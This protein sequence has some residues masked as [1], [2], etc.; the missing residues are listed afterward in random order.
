MGMKNNGK[1]QLIFLWAARVL[2][3]FAMMIALTGCWSSI[4][5][6]HRAFVRVMMLDRTDK[7]IEVTLGFPLP[8]QIPSG[9]TSGSSGGSNSQVYTYTSKTAPSIGEAYRNL[10][11][12]LS[13]KIT[14]G[15]LRNIII[16]K[17]FAESK[18]DMLALSDFLVREPLIHINAS[19]FMTQS[20]ASHFAKIP[21]IFERFPSVILANYAKQKNTLIVT[22]K[23]MLIALYAGG[24]FLLPELTFEEITTVDKESNNSKP[25][26]NWLGTGGAGV[27]SQGK[28]NGMLSEKQTQAMIWLYQKESELNYNITSPTDGK[29]VSLLLSSGKRKIKPAVHGDDIRFLLH[30]TISAGVLSS[31]SSIDFD[32]PGQ[33]HNLEQEINSELEDQ[34][35]RAFEQFRALQTDPVGLGSLLKWHYPGVWKKLQPDWRQR[36]A[37]DVTVKPQFEI[38]VDWNG[39]AKKHNWDQDISGSAEE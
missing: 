32:N 9:G 22:I 26:S 20:Q 31:D 8:N 35:Q 24:D 7:G 6:N 27:F 15:Q 12:D 38:T 21:A 33:L 16:G 18:G 4:E 23:D 2:L 34:V 30:C 14:F 19:L 25:G 17:Q 5:L 37:S 11:A 3:P 29:K 39:A 1:K 10:Q 13:R 28:M 36:I